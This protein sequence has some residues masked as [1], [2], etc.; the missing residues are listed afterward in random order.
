MDYLQRNEFSYYQFHQEPHLK[1]LLTP[2]DLQ[3]AENVLK[4]S[5]TVAYDTETDGLAWWNEDRICGAAFAARPT[6]DEEIQ[7][8]YVP[9]RHLTGQKQITPDKAIEFQRQFLG[10]PNVTKLAHNIKFDE[11]MA[12][13]DGLKI[14]GTRVDT[15][16]EAKLFHEDRPGGLKA[17]LIMDL[18]DTS[19]K[20][21]DQILQGAI[22]Q[23]IAAMGMNKTTYMSKFGYSALDIWMVGKYACHDVRATWLLHEF[24]EKKG[25]REFYQKSPRQYEG[26]EFM[27]IYDIEMEL[28]GILCNAERIGIPINMERLD[29]LHVLLAEEQEKAEAAFFLETDLEYFKLSSDAEVRDRLL[30]HFKVK[31]TKTTKTGALAVDKDVLGRLVPEHPTI[32]HLLRYRE[33]SKKLSVDLRPFIDKHGVLHGN[34]K[35]VGTTTGRLACSDPNLQNQ[36]T[37]D[38]ERKK[39]ND[40][41][42]PESIKHVF[43]VVRSVSD[44]YG[45]FCYPHGWDAAKVAFY[46][47]FVDYSQV[48]LRVLSHFTQDSLL[49]KTYWENG[50][51]HDQVE[52][53]V[54]GTGKYIDPKTGEEVNGPNRRKAKV[55]NFGL[56]YRMSPQGFARQIPSV[57]E[58]EAQQYFDEYHRKFPRVE[59]FQQQFF[60][61]IRTHGCVFQNMF[62]RTRHV[63]D[64]ISPD[65][66]DRRRA[67]RVSIATLIQGQ[68]A[69]LTKES[70]V[71]IDRWLRANGLRSRQTLTVHDEIQ[72]DGPVDEFAQVSRGVKSIMEDFP[73]FS[74][75]IIADAE[76]SIDSWATKRNVPG[77]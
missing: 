16:I 57:T 67:E 13:Q 5:D 17:R 42:D 27:G 9:Y 38:A 34:F 35:Q 23:H 31:L 73:D 22:K 74:V 41:I 21:H 64:M 20:D 36:A 26:R 1:V 40:G 6:P 50:D 54:F 2:D 68:A 76:W 71:R 4:S 70:M 72:I 11:H 7:S 61:W 12:H 39:A 59:A 65:K 62:G 60:A 48:E 24:Y 37:D 45:I 15:M 77:L 51:I 32:R 75:P 10:N 66:R 52:Q 14:V 30:K 63:P 25:V 69:E 53:A 56:S 58:A 43:S 28:T 8:F 46:R 29:K 19:A 18:G 47:L 44:P 33:V 3:Y 49:L 55:I